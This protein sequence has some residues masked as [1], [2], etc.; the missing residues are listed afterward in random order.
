MASA[1]LAKIFPNCCGTQLYECN[2]Q[3]IPLSKE[4]ACARE[5][6]RLEKLRQDGILK[7]TLMWT[8]GYPFNLGMAL[9]ILMTF[10]EMH[11]TMF[12]QQDS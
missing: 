2:D 9:F 11:S 5:F 1:S 7:L 3:F 6:Y 8:E 10:V 12:R 4:I